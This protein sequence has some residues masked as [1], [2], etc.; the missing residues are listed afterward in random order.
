VTPVTTRLTPARRRAWL[1]LLLAVLALGATVTARPPD[2]PPLYDGI[3]FPDEPYRWVQPPAGQSTTPQPATPASAQALVTDGRSAATRAFSSEQGPQVAFA[4]ADGA[5]T[6]PAGASEVTV[7]LTPEAVP[8]PGLPGTT[9]V[10]NLHRFSLT[11]PDGAQAGL[12][13]EGSVIV[14]L[15]ASA[16]TPLS[17]VVCQWDGST[18][19]QVPTRQ[20]G[21]EIYAADLKS[22]DPFAVLR[23]DAGV[24][25]TVAAPAGPPPGAPAATGAVEDPA[26]AP[27]GGT[28]GLTLWLIVGGVV[29]LL[30]AALVVLRRRT[31]DA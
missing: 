30:G 21:T 20:V 12:A 11:T 27:S 23:F 4:L 29:V 6:A 2:S 24:T 28:S 3:G 18:W 15:R 16:Q 22:L 14:N 5:L 9:V 19:T 25:P 1:A 10:S 17:V 26:A 31:G 13:P 7:T 8:G